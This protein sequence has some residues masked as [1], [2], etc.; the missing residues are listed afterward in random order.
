MSFEER[1]G[2]ALRSPERTDPERSAA[3]LTAVT[4]AARRSRRRARVRRIGTAAL[5]VIAVTGAGVGLWAILPGGESQTTA[6]QSITLPDLGGL[7]EDQAWARLRALGLKPDVVSVARGLPKAGTV[8]TQRPTA[9]SALPATGTRV[10]I[11]VAAISIRID[12]SGAPVTRPMFA[13]MGC[14][15]A[16]CDVLRVAAWPRPGDIRRMTAI[17]DGRPITMRPVAARP[18]YWQGSLP[19][20]GVAARL[21]AARGTLDGWFG[22]TPTIV[23]AKLIVRMGNGTVRRWSQ[24]LMVGPGWG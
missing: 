11:V 8:L 22:G 17:I 16:T 19:R 12:T 9:G 3:A 13:G 24:P 20:S 4:E 23:D 14:M 5:P 2:A 21:L 18:I 6:P 15:P 10:R 7:R 1:L